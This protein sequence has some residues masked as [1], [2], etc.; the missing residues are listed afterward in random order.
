MSDEF[1]LKS[2][3]RTVGTL[4]GRAVWTFVKRFVVLLLLAIVVSASAALLVWKFAVSTTAIS[5]GMS[6]TTGFAL[7]VCYVTAGLLWALHRSYRA[8]VEST[9]PM[10]VQQSPELLNAVVEPLVAR[11]PLQDRKIAV[12]DARRALQEL[13]GE[14]PAT[15]PA[16]EGRLGPLGTVQRLIA[17]R[18]ARTELAVARD[19]LE[20]LERNGESHVS[21]ASLSRYLQ[22]KL[23]GS[24]AE[25]ARSHAR[26]FGLVSAVLAF[27]LVVAP[28]TLVWLLP[29]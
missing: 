27:L 22:Y 14:G 6:V 20:S 15:A 24:V 18:C 19:V 23:V 16:A 26:S 13:F 29:A 8:A 7:L 10:F 5:T 2:L 4:A 3:V 28:V 9:V 12:A 21:V 25:I 1:L 17:V 11:C